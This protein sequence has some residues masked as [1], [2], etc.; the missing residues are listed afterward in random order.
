MDFEKDAGRER[1][2]GVEVWWD[3]FVSGE[4]TMMM[5]VG[6]GIIFMSGSSSTGEDGTGC[7]S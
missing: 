3:G 6:S 5:V 4:M 7:V 2:E 1:R